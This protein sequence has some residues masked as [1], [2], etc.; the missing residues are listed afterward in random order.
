MNK[1]LSIF[2]DRDIDCPED[3]VEAHKSLAELHLIFGD[4]PTARK[5]CQN[6]LVMATEL[7]IPLVVECQ[8]LMESLDREAEEA[9]I[10]QEEIS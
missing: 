5:H 6:A 9:K 8:T 3:E 7:S 4:I 2:S 10:V 1:A